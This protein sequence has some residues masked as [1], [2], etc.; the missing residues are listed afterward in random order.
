M[1]RTSSRRP[2]PRRT[3]PDDLTREL[4][5]LRFHGRC[6]RCGHDG[7]TIQHRIPRALGGTSRPEINFPSNLLWVCGSGTTGC[8]GHME[9]QRTEAYAKGWLVRHGQDPATVPVELWD[10]RRVLVDDEGEFLELD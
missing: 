4:V 8:H 7:A 6:C 10:G 3:G 1:R 9:S 5:R 2:R